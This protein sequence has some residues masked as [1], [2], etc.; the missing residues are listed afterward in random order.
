MLATLGKLGI[1]PDRLLKVQ[2]AGCTYTGA[3]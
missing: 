2:Q 1:S 3:K